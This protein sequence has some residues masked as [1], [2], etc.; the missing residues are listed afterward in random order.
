[1]T[2]TAMKRLLVAAVTAGVAGLIWFAQDGARLQAQNR[3]NFPIVE[4]LN[5]GQLVE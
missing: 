1:M 5:V 2:R 4:P 3:M